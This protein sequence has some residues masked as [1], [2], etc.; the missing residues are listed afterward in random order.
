MRSAWIY[1]AIVSA[2]LDLGVPL[3]VCA[4]LT[5][6]ETSEILEAHNRW[7][8]IHQ[9]A[10]LRWSDELARYAQAWAETLVRRYPGRL[11]H[12]EDHKGVRPEAGDLGYGG[13]GENLYW[14]SALLWP[15][16]RREAELD[17]AP[18]D[19]INS[20][21]N[22]VEW[23]DFGTGRCSPR[24]EDGC[25]HFTQMVWMGTTAVGCG[26]AIGADQSQV[27]ACSYDP[28]GNYEGEHADNVRRPTGL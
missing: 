12:S 27:W 28:P 7:R 5:P 14:G 8:A 24:A 15:D 16:G 17:L 21:G 18:Q 25:G 13:W 9:A 4:Q 23:Y 3:G 10:P 20:W 26:R 19:V 2:M 6:S 11:L 22:E 1:A